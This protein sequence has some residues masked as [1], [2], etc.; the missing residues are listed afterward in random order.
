[1]K[2]AGEILDAHYDPI[3]GTEV[4]LYRMASG[5][6][7][8]MHKDCDADLP[9]QIMFGN[10]LDVLRGTYNKIVEHMG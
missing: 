4:M 3:T 6:Y 9:V 8:L 1:M 2:H 5:Q 10:D 7:R